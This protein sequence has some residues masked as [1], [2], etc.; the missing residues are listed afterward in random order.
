[1]RRCLASRSLLVRK[2]TWISSHNF[3]KRLACPTTRDHVRRAQHCSRLIPVIS[4]NV[5]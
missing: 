1:M 5:T 3:L 2:R 4:V